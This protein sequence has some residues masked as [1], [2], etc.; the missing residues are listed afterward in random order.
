MAVLSLSTLDHTRFV[1]LSGY[2]V[3]K[4]FFSQD[5]EGLKIGKKKREGMIQAVLYK[6]KDPISLQLVNCTL[7]KG[8]H[9]SHVEV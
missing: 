9:L 3:L 8:S 1:F 6:R 7:H 4:S 5:V 2:L